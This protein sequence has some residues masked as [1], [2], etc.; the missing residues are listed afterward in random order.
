MY[1]Y[2]CQNCG[3]LV[4]EPMKAYG[5]SGR[6]CYCPNSRKPMPNEN[7][8][9]HRWQR[10]CNGDGLC[11]CGAKLIEPFPTKTSN[12]NKCCDG[13]CNHDDCC[14]KI[15]EN[16]THTP[17]QSWEEDIRD[18]A[19]DPDCHDMLIG[20]VHSLLSSKE[21]EVIEEVV[22]EIEKSLRE[23]DKKEGKD[24]DNWS[25]TGKVV[26]YYLSSL[27]QKLEGKINEK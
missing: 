5:Y 27:K 9:K 12:E 24:I 21:K 3:G 8:H 15:P 14:G 2:T 10:L 17:T 4:P 6:Y 13:E 20:V 16:C 18:L 22:G 26:Y 7:N 23:I 25:Q 11:E 1:D 19:R